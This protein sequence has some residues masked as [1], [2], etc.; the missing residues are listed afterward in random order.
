MTTSSPSFGDSKVEF[1]PAIIASNI[2][3]HNNIVLEMEKDQY[4]K[5][6]E[7]L[8]THAHSHCVLH[9]IVPSTDKKPPIDSSTDEYEQWA[10]FDSTVLQWIYSTIFIDLLTTLLEPYFTAMEAWNRLADIF[11]DNQNA[12]VITL[13]QEFSNTHMENFSNVSTYYQHP[14]MLSNQLRN[15][16]SPVNHHCLVVQLI[17]GLLK[18]YHNVSTLILQSNPLPAFYQARSMLTLEE[19]GMVKM[20]STGSHSS[21]HTTQQRPS[22]DTS[23]HANCRPRNCACSRGSQGRGRGHGKRHGHQSKVPNAPPSWSYPL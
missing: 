5:Q 14:K 22:E 10:T 1:H 23:Q 13:E 3:N 21:M 7:L 12:R 18:A 17:Y 6:P 11:Q 8:R 9:H 16:D 15:V 20:T 2:K 19:T 4:G